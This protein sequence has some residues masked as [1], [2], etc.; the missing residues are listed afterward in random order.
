MFFTFF[1][2]FFVAAIPVVVTALSSPHNYLSSLSNIDLN[3]GQMMTPP[4]VPSTS[5][6][7]PSAGYE[8][9]S[10]P[11]F[12]TS[13]SL[14]LEVAQDIAIKT[15]Q[16]CRM[17]KFQPMTV[18]VLDSAGHLIVQHRMDGC[19][20]GALP[21]SIAKANTCIQFGMSSRTYFTKYLSPSS[22]PDVYVRLVNQLMI[23]GGTVA[24]FQGGILLRD[25][26]GNCVGA[27][28]VSGAAGDEDEYCGLMGIQRSPL[29]N[30]AV[31]TDPAEHSCKTCIA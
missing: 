13:K 26:E 21:M 30:N 27:V 7:H 19:H 14:S 15:T 31:L 25:Q 24:A 22:T 5:T 16:V 18:V 20:P 6:T 28:G 8:V 1:F 17:N 11:T 29:A 4:I 10:T 9:V 3:H 12:V 23:L 2:P